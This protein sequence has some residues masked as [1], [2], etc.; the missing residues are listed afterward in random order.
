MWFCI[1]RIVPYNGRNT[2]WEMSR[3]ISFWEKNRLIKHVLQR[4]TWRRRFKKLRRGCE[5]MNRL[6][7]LLTFLL[8]TS[9]VDASSRVKYCWMYG[10]FYSTSFSTQNSDSERP[11]LHSGES[12][13]TGRTSLDRINEIE[14]AKQEYM[15][16][17]RDNYCLSSRSETVT[18]QKNLPCSALLTC[19]VS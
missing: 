12:G 9:I 19:P 13:K 18:G 15:L 17:N 8:K 3:S 5:Q 7:L 10:Y 11:K 1:R 16:G 14:K 2:G 6:I 4:D